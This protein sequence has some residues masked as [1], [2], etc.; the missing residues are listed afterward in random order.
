MATYS[1]LDIVGAVVGPG[2]VCPLATGAAPAEEG[3]TIEMHEDKDNLV[4]GA[5]GEAM[6]NLHASMA[7]TITFRLL[8]TSD[9][10]SLLFVMYNVQQVSSLLWGHNVIQLNNI[11]TGDNITAI[12]AA[13]RRA[14]NMTY[15]KDGGTVEWAF[16]CSRIFTQTGV[17]L[18]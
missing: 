15:A 14:P 10:N 16:N 18:P 7:G 17:Y 6:H 1:F 3:V 9:I 5:D 8:K 11:V 13:F 12:Q 4:V 2:G